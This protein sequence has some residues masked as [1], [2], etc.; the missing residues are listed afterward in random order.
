MNISS[1][2]NYKS[3][4]VAHYTQENITSNTQEMSQLLT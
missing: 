3:N 1:S 4:K 2:S